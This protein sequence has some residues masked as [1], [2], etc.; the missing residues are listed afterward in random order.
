LSIRTSVVINTPCLP[1]AAKKLMVSAQASEENPIEAIAISQKVPRF[2]KGGF[3][4]EVRG[5]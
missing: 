3:K 5:G 2:V 4:H 1:A